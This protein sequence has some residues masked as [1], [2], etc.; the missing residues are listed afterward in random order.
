MKLVIGIII[1]VVLGVISN[2]VSNFLAPKAEKRKRL[3][4]SLFVALIALSITIAL[5][6]EPQTPSPLPTPKSATSVALRVGETWKQN[7][8]ELTLV[9]INA[10][11]NRIFAEWKIKN[12]TD[13]SIPSKVTPDNFNALDSLGRSLKVIG[14]GGQYSIPSSEIGGVLAPNR[15]INFWLAIE[16]DVT[17]SSAREV[18]ITAT[19]IY[20]IEQARWK[21]RIDFYTPASTSLLTPLAQSY[22]VGEDFRQ[23]CINVGHWEPYAYLS[24]PEYLSSEMPALI[25]VLYKLGCLEK[26]A[27][28]AWGFHAM[29]GSLV[30]RKQQEQDSTIYGLSTPLPQS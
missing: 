26:D 20:S 21:A 7:G 15:E 11:D 23:N 2:L 9:N 13:R 6:P 3:V 24:T 17:Y 22:D 25:P 8:I 14:L 30:I 29:N 16:F 27:E 1:A 18:T 4:W 19:D 12:T 28:D 10:K 5:L